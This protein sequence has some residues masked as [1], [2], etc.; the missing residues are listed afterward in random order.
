MRYVCNK[1]FKP[2]IK[3]AICRLN[4]T[5][6]LLYESTRDFLQLKFEGR[7]NEK[8]WMAEKD[9]LLHELDRC[10]EQLTISCDPDREKEQEMVI[11]RLSQSEKAARTSRSEEVKVII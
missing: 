4:K 5:Q 11:F 10:R 2:K 6:K 8:S 7:A 9:R 1:P 3:S